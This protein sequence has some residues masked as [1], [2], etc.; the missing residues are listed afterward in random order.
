MQNGTD[1]QTD[2]QIQA[3]GNTDYLNHLLTQAGSQIL[4]TQNRS[5]DINDL[6]HQECEHHNLVHYPYG[7]NAFV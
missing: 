2:C 5:S 1:Q 7:S 3:K 6:E 4:G